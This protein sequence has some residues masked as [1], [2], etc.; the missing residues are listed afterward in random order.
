MKFHFKNINV[1]PLFLLLFVVTCSNVSEEMHQSA[2]IENY[3]IISDSSEIIFQR[4]IDSTYDTVFDFNKLIYFRNRMNDSIG[5]FKGVEGQMRDSLKSTKNQLVA[6]ILEYGKPKIEK[7]LIEIDTWRGQAFQWEQKIESAKRNEEK[8]K[9]SMVRIE[10]VINNSQSKYD[11]LLRQIELK[12]DTML[13]KKV[14]SFKTN[15]VEAFIAKK[16]IHDI[17]I[18][19]NNKR[20]FSFQSFCKYLIDN[21]FGEALM[22]T[23]GG[24]YEPDFS[25]QGL[26][27]SN[28]KIIKGIDTTN[29][30]SGNFYLQ[31]NG[32]FYVD[33]FG[34]FKVKKTKE[35]I[36]SFPDKKPLP[37]FAT[38]SGPMLVID[39]KMNPK[40]SLN[41]DN[42][43]IR[44]GVGEMDNGKVVFIISSGKINFYDFAL[45]FKD[46]FGCKNALYLDGAISEMYFKGQAQ[47]PS[48]NFGPMIGV[49]PKK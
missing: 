41:S 44:S 25:A 9:D 45:I 36:E 46:Y 16:G 3:S 13:G 40:L 48:G 7:S 12:R 29:S 37:K 5:Y 15:R 18:S 20:G 26:L 39:G 33:S 47:K 11:S 1:V 24:M 22:I 8:L 10:P 6:K 34:N 42:L 23:N 27:I 35:Y 38:Q 43:N 21:K 19:V 17:F 28:A 14:F 30:K 31:P 4:T 32:V 2:E 49:L